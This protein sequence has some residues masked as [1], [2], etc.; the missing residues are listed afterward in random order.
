MSAWQPIA[1]APRDGTWVLVT[2]IDGKPYSACYDTAE[3]T[4]YDWLKDDFFSGGWTDYDDD[5]GDSPH[6]R[7]YD[8]THWMP[9]P[10]PPTA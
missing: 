8:P 3:D 4:F 1:T 7:R 9:L 10:E 6:T 5:G 2:S